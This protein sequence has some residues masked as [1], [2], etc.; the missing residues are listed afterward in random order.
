MRILIAPN[1]FKGSLSVLEAAQAFSKGVKAVLPGAELDLMPIADGGDGVMDCLLAARG[2][3]KVFASV[4]GPL[5]RETRAPYALLADGTACVEMAS[6]SGLALVP[7][8]RRQP[9]LASSYGCGQLIAEAASRGARTI[10]FGLGGSAGSDGGAGLAR[11]LGAR[12]LDARGRDI[13]P[14][15]RG[16]LALDRIDASAL[17]RSLRGVRVVG[18]TDVANPL[19]GPRGSAAVYGPQKGASAAEVKLIE[20]ALRNLARVAARDLGVSPAREPGAGAAG[21]CGFG[22]MA[23][24]GARLSPGAAFVLQACGARE[25]LRRAD[26]ALSGEGRLDRTSFFGKAPV[27][28]ARLAKKERVPCALVCGEVDASARPRLRGAGVSAA[29]S[30]LEAGAS[31]DDA[32]RR[33]ARWAAKAAALAIKSL[34]LAGVLAGVVAAADFGPADA[35]YFHRDEPGKLDRCL[36]ALQQ[37]PEG[38]GRE[39]RLARVLVRRGEAAPA[40]KD[41]LGA[42]DLAQEAGRRA[43][44]EEPGNAE[45]HFWHAVAMGRYGQAKGIFKSLSLVDPIREEARKTLELDPKHGGA[46]HLLAEVD[47]QVPG[48]A[49]GDKKRALGEFEKAL[50]L[51]PRHSSN[52]VP[53]AKAY[54]KF[55]R[56]DDARRV[57][58]KLA[59][60]TRD[61]CDDPPE[62]AADQK[63]G[64]ELRS[65]FK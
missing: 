20:A 16:L 11:A 10:V 14:G 22:L 28:L 50:E 65:S 62:L 56:P 7:A 41:K 25:R 3:R 21:G 2:G 12:L 36:S 15:A 27:E 39:W 37:A 53:L 60:I 29:V 55:D 48:F 17:T 51:A 35:L 52:Y 43:A 32:M 26:A 47:W 42:F 54:L 63:A 24:L 30:L 18:I 13:G 58:D 46:W 49:G 64:A 9:L 19:L 6:A 34:A 5:G 31:R 45:A 44:A 40:K 57:L 23:F 8:A 1:A 38:A 4:R 33:A 59:A 61:D